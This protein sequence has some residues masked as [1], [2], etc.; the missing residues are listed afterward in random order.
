MSSLSASD[1]VLVKELFV[2]SKTPVQELEKMLAVFDFDQTIVDGNSDVVAIDLINPTN[3]IPDRK[4]FPKNWTQYMQRVFDIIKTI[5][6]PAEQIIDVVSLMRPND[7]M[8]KLMRALHENNFDIIVA[9][10][11]NSLFIY[12]WLKY[13]ELLDVVSCIYTNPATVVDNAIKI[14]PYSVQTKC[15]WCTTNMC[16]GAIVEEHILNKNQKYDKILYFG[17]G[18]NDLCPILKLTKNDIAF[19]R[20]G[21]ILEN[22]LKS[23]S[24]PAEVMPWCTGENIYEFLKSSKLI[25]A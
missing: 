10:D 21:Y 16:K 8:P 20:L 17:D 6:I 15:D 2:S 19:P 22:L 1:S 3:L 11:S 7:G 24:T 23:H 5:K 25:S 9:S 13:N 12:N 14:E 18:H 4:D